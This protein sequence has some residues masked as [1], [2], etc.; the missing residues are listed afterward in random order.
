M[1]DGQI[2]VD[3]SGYPIPST[4]PSNLGCIQPRWSGSIGTNL[5]YKGLKLTVL[6]GGNAGGQ[7]FSETSA[8]QQFD[9]QDPLTTYNN[10]QPYV[11]PN[12]VYQT[13]PETYV[14]NTT[15]LVPYNLWVSVAPFI[16]SVNNVIAADFVKLRELSL[17]YA[18]PAKLFA[19]SKSISGVSIKAY[20][21]NI[22]MWTPKSNTYVD[23]ELNASGAT[24]V[25]GFEFY[26]LPSLRNFGGG[27]KIDF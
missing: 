23:P 1:H 11:L 20:G 13:G 10:R 12:S 8:I 5:S 18:L 19:K 14:T 6:F 7:F 21:S 16:N 17:S 9:G 22:W 25:Q 3:A 2:V 26:Q 24:N 4:T 15:K 27:V